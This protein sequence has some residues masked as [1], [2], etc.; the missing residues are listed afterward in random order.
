MHPQL[1]RT[2]YILNGIKGMGY[3]KPE[4]LPQ[5][6]QK[7]EKTF[8]SF[9]KS[10]P[11]PGKL[12]KECMEQLTGIAEENSS[13]YTFFQDTIMNLHDCAILS[14]DLTKT[15]ADNQLLRFFSREAPSTIERKKRLL[16][17]INKMDRLA[18]KSTMLNNVIYQLADHYDRNQ[19]YSE[20]PNLSVMESLSNTL[21]ILYHK[22]N[23]RKLHAPEKT[24][25]FF[26]TSCIKKH[27]PHLHEEKWE[28]KFKPLPLRKQCC[29][30]IKEPAIVSFTGA[31]RSLNRDFSKG[32]ELR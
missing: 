23:Q 18:E 14:D 11:I 31:R 5:C 15:M 13:F 21:N 6:I 20:D 17:K 3:I 28:N 4:L 10:E 30:E 2:L 9:F 24:L 12:A 26:C 25:L 1:N 29:P 16:D 19:Q 8:D 22:T 27:A 32:W 7:L